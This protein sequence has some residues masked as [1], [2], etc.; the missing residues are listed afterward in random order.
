MVKK[1]GTSSSKPKK[2]REPSDEGKKREGVASKLS[3]PQEALREGRFSRKAIGRKFSEYR[4][5][6]T[7]TRRPTREEFSTIAKVA[8]LGIIIIGV[9]GFLI[10]LAMVQVP[11]SLGANNATQEMANASTSSEDNA[12]QK[13]TNATA[14]S[15]ITSAANNTGTVTTQSLAS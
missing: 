5:I 14:E 11:A 3:K 6:L 8:A 13:I 7:L 4:R 15:T 12:I 2:P 1:Q 10:Y 9:V